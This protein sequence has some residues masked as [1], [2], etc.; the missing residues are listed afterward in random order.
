[1]AQLDD[2]VPIR[3]KLAFGIGAT[4]EAATNWIFTALTFF[5]YNQIVLG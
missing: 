3:T 2:A 1:M 5:Y 4:G